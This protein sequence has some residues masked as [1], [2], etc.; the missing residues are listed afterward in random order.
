[1][2]RG[3]CGLLFSLAGFFF[4]SPVISS[5]RAVNFGS[6]C[7]NPRIKTR[8]R[9][10]V[11]AAPRRPA[12]VI[13]ATLFPARALPVCAQMWLQVRCARPDAV[14]ALP[15]DGCCKRR[16]FRLLVMT[17]LLAA[18]SG[19]VHA[20]KI[21][22]GSPPQSAISG[23]WFKAPN[24]LPSGAPTSADDVTI[25]FAGNPPPVVGAPGAVALNLTVG[26]SG[27]GMLTIQ[28]GGTLTDVLGA[29]ANGAGSGM[30]TVTGTGSTWTNS[31]TLQVGAQGAGTLMI[32]NGGMVSS[33]GGGSVGLLAGSHGVVTVTGAGSAWNNIAPNAGLNIGSFGTGTLTIENGGK[34]INTS[35]FAA[36]IGSSAGSQGTV[37]VTGTDSTWTNN[38][39]LNIGNSGTGTLTIDNGGAV[40]NTSANIANNTGSHGAVTVT[41][42]GST[43]TSNGKLFIGGNSNGPGGTG[44][45][46][47]INGGRVIATPAT[48]IWS[49]GTLAVDANF[50]F[51]TP[52]LTVNGGT[53]RTLADTVFPNSAMLAG[54]GAILDSNG[55]NSTFSGTF[56]GTGSLTKISAGTVI[57]TA[58]NTYTGGTTINAG[59][60]QLGNGGTTGSI[61]GNVLDNG[62]LVFNQGSG[63][64]TFA[65]AINGSGSVVKLGSD[66]LVLTA[67][68]TFSGGTTIQDGTLVVGTLIAADQPISTALGTGNVFLDPGTLRTTSAA[69]GVPLIINVGGNYTQ[70]PG[71]TLALGI[72]GTQGEQY[73]HV[74]VNGSA[75]LGGTLVVNSLGGFHP[76]N[77]NLFEVLSSGGKRS[78]E[79]AT[80]T[81]N[82]NIDPNLRRVD[83]YAPNGAALLYIATAAPTPTPPTPGPSPSPS[84]SPAP[85]PTPVPPRPPI[86]VVIPEPLPPVNPDEPIDPRF[87][88]AALDPTVEQ[89]TSMFEIPF[90]GANTQRFNLNDR[91]TQIQRGST[92]FVSA[93]PAAPPPPPTGKE[94]ANKEVVPPAF[95][96]GPTNRWGVWVNGWGDWVNVND[97]NGAKG[98]NFTTGGVSVGVDYRITD[99]LAVG[100]FGTYAHTWTSLNPGSI[101][102]N[103]G[104]GGLYAT[105]WNHGF[106]ISGGVYAGGNSYDTSR[107]ELTNTLANGSTSGYEVS[108]FVD[109]GYDFHFGDLSVGPVF[110]AQYTNVHINGFTETGSFLPLN[111]HSDSEESWRTDL[112]VQASYAWHVGNVIVIP[113][114]RAAWEHE[115]KYS[116]LPITFSSPIF[117]GVSATTFGPHEGHD[118]AIINA[119]VGTQW[120]PRI[121][122]YVGYQGQLGR[123]NYSANGVTGTIGFSF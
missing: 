20:Q 60:L 36:N 7:S 86:I 87:L 3:L 59:T 121:S 24:W 47:I 43:W 76:T 88:L 8:R 107:N 41:G 65:G 99:Y 110:A 50:T 9:A 98:Y 62:T 34:V 108:T 118:S 84:P 77:L 5:L 103:T 13:L 97:D 100:I 32:Q 31:G 120:T 112:G 73:D 57:L 45:L 63:T 123:D 4:C 70:A 1:M 101:D 27:T 16:L 54:S 23:D 104:R 64:T 22:I 10:G 12:A 114:L 75:T 19:S 105:Y 26:L 51:S 14:E 67:N 109:T 66:A 79:F 89:L 2:Q 49:T 90:S 29:V 38:V 106:Y 68:N 96:P 95:V 102:V 117:G 83:I 30:V 6:G 40:S 48:T 25:N 52:S 56:T 46:E 11:V 61:V 39:G 15:V 55:F 115:Y 92:G 85:S 44:L 111:I 71:G 94:V 53:I 69:T 82:I 28:N 91:M 37:T 58:D 93:V 72:G 33:A 17:V 18:V 35:G 116:R 80:V 81:D 113:S 78:G 42:A 21:W 74:Q 122:T 119:G